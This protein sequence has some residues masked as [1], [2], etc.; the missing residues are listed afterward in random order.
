MKGIFS[1]KPALFQ[2]GMLIYFSFMGLLFSILV[3]FIIGKIAGEELSH[4]GDAFFYTT[5]FSHFF[6][7]ILIF[8]LPALSIAFLC[9]KEP[10]S[11][12]CIKKSIDTKAI[13]LSA[14]MVVLL[15]PTVDITSYLNSNIHLPEFM[16]PIEN[17]I[18]ET[19]EYAG[20]IIDKLLSKE[21]II[22][23]AVNILVIGV[24]AGIGEELLFR[25]VLLSII[26][27]KIK[28][29]HIAIWIVAFIFS[30]IHFQFLG[31]IPRMILGAFMGYLLYWT[32]NIWV[33]VFAHFLNNAMSITGYKIN[34]YQSTSD[35]T[36]LITE[37]PT[38]TE[39]ILIITAAITG[40]ALFAL[41]ARKIKQIGA[42]QEA[43]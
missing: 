8:L 41:C 15:F 5:Q 43:T 25:G 27:K 19:E 7:A 28:N 17:W 20:K 13:L 22:P 11:F 32:N 36:A 23:F 10:L 14:A 12:L 16:A 2:L 38:V 31:F 39:I 24:M 29:P 4:G 6:S 1:E 18:R 35:S 21:G 34:L 30:A 26:R 40:L 3:Q 37:N 42:L 33:P 9:S